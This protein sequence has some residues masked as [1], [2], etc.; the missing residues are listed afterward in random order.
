MWIPLR[1]HQY[2]NNTPNGRR[3]FGII[4]QGLTSEK[5]LQYETRR[6]SQ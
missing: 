1:D 2:P 6:V 5:D 4:M 3:S